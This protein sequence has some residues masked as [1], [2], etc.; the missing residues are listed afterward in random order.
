MTEAVAGPRVLVVD[1]DRA[2][3]RTMRRLLELNG[4]Q[5]D[6]AGSVSAARE[7]LAQTGYALVLCDVNMPGGSGLDLLESVAREF[8]DTATVMVTGV[9]DREVAERALKMGA[10]G[11]V[12]KPFERNEIL[13]GVSNALRRRELEIENRQHRARLA[14]QIQE[15]TAHL[16]TALQEVE[17]AQERLRESHELTISKLAI[18]AE[19]RDGATALHVDRMSQYAALL[20]S[21]LGK[22][23][24]EIRAIGL[25]SMMHDVGKIGV[26]DRILLK[27]GKLDPEEFE[28]VRT[29]CEIGHRILHDPSSELLALAASIALTHHEWFDG[30]GYPQGL[31]GESIPAEGRIAAIADVFDALTSNRVYRRALALGEAVDI[32]TAERGTHFDPAMLDVF[33][34]ALDEVL[35]IKAAPR[36]DVT[37]SASLRSG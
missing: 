27:P 9:D 13:I 16:W 17:Q 25:A 8:P 1:D 6:G 30:S 29:H 14:N 34:G 24:R 31:A 21:K 23:D 36:S 11:Y 32:M 22:D 10:Y 35:A 18:A 20:A 12:I 26:P 19:Y 3:V 37:D 15:R 2:A 28:V 33:L 4:Y 5:A 7:L